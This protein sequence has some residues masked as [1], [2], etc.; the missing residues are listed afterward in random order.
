MK[1]SLES[2]KLRFPAKTA[3]LFFKFYVHMDS[4]ELKILGI[5]GARSG[6]KGVPDKNIRF[7]AGKPL[8]GW[9]IETAKR[10]KYLNR[11]IVSTDSEKYAVLARSFGAETPFLRPEELARD[12]STDF[13]YVEH[14]VKWLEA[15]EG[16]L[17]DIV[18]R[19]MATVPLQTAE[20]IDAC[21]EELLRDKEAHSSV[22]IAEARQH[23]QKALK[24]VD[25]GQ[26]GKYLAGYITGEGKDTNPTARQ[27]YAKAYFRANIV[28]CRSMVIKEFG[29]LTGERVRFHIIPQERA[30]D[31]DSLI[32]FYI[33]EQ[34]MKK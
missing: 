21:I 5:I 34:L 4:S 33:V 16:Y 22:V 17:P 12:S 2:W 19:L 11:L 13:E 30:V 31:I 8:I 28:A 23:P 20:D 15:N 25:D 24:L 7:L 27:A 29:S 14:A 6:S 3:A 18:V 10:S 26:G 32:D 1:V 9:I